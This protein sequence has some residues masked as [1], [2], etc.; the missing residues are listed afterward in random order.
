MRAKLFTLISTFI[1][2]SIAQDDW[3][4][5]LSSKERGKSTFSHVLRSTAYYKDAKSNQLFTCY[6]DSK[7]IPWE[8]VNDHYCDCIDGSDEPI[9]SACISNRQFECKQG[10]SHLPKR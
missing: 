8:Y 9:N 3:I 2:C 1:L 10:L 6:D 5:S 4:E 7:T